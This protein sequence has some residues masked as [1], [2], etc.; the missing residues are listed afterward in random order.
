MRVGF[1]CTVL[2][3]GV[4]QN[5]LDG[6][7]SYT[8]ELGRALAAV[9]GVRLVPTSFGVPLGAQDPFP[10]RPATVLAPYARQLALSTLSGR[11]FRGGARLAQ[12]VE[13]FHAT[14]HLI[15]RFA[16][17]P[18]LATLM[19]AIPLSHPHW[20]RTRLGWLKRRLW[21]HA[22]GWAD[23]VVTISDAS[24]RDIVEHFG[25]RP[26][27]IS[28]TPLGVDARYFE[29]I[30]AA[31]RAEVCRRHGLPQQFFL[32][33]GTLQPRKNLERLLDAH[34]SLPLALQKECPLVVVGRAG[35]GCEALVARLNRPDPRVRWLAY[36]PDEEVRALLQTA[37]ALV[38]ASLYEGFGLPV[39]E[40]FASGLPVITSATTSLPEV[41]AG[42]ALLV[43]PLDAGAIGDAMRQIVATPGLAATLARAGMRRAREMSWTACA[44]KTLEV[45]KQVLR[46]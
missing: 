20:V 44:G 7:G 19:D 8:R 40:A 10:A 43:D 39:L 23:H 27:K 22:A 21:R 1:G 36:L 4:R 16:K 18:V 32:F 2:A 30:D 34:A 45:Y 26:E 24:K 15:P 13:L 28:I 29:P 12:D 6:I 9:P 35:W 31:R 46:G 37:R 38:F 33:V 41:A 42:A 11:P 3:R 14:D 5:A 25:I 17:V